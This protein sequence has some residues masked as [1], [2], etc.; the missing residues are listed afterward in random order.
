MMVRKSCRAAAF[1]CEA[2]SVR[3]RLRMFLR[4]FALVFL[5]SVAVVKL[6]MCEAMDPQD[7]AA[8][9][10]LNRMVQVVASPTRQAFH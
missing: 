4:K 3:R 2:V 10:V 6:D 1:C 5:E 8:E 7:T 9:I